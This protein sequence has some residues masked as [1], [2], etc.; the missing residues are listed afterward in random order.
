VLR[1]HPRPAARSRDSGKRCRAAEPL[2]FCLER[3]K[4]VVEIGGVKGKSGDRPD[5]FSPLRMVG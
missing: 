1:W 3:Y 4:M 2:V 5:I